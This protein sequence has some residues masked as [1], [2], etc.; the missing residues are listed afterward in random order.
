MNKLLKRLLPYLLVLGVFI[1]LILFIIDRGSRLPVRSAATNAIRSAAP[2]VS[3]SLLHNLQHPLSLLLL[4]VLVIVSAARLFGLLARQLKQPAVVGE[5]VAGICL[6]PSLLGWLWP[7]STSW[8]FPAGSLQSLSFLG[9]IG[10]AFFMFVVGMQMDTANMK[11][12]APHAVMISHVSIV[13][14]FFL[15]VGLAYY[16]YPQFAPAQVG[17]IPFA[18]F[19]GIS[20]SITA[21][22]VL[23]RIVQER[24]LGGTPI[25]S[26]AI[27]CAAAD[28]ITAWCLLAVVVATARSGSLAGSLLTVGLA[29]A[30]VCLMIYGVKPLLEKTVGRMIE[31]GRRQPMVTIVFIVILLS[32]WTAEVIGI[33]ALFGAFFAGVIMPSNVSVKKLIADKI[34]DVSMLLLL[35][36]FFAFTGLRTQVGLIAG[37]Q[38]WW[39]FALI[40]LVAVGGKLCGSAL[41]ARIMGQSWR[42][43][44]SIGAL[45]NTRGLMELVVLNIGYELGI[46]TPPVFA[47]MVLMALATTFMTGPLL[48]LFYRPALPPPPTSALVRSPHD[49]LSVA[50]A[51]GEVA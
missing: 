35:P 46:F 8:L 50:A 3:T 44:L 25:G 18:L 16:L 11:H 33:H 51:G 36:I 22:P 9:Q 38:L 41:T 40:M 19:M 21:F 1:S 47:L 6:G 48:D 5:I 30:F 7:A 31:K 45:M 24:G 26:L 43:S 4:Q 20:M 14:P 10:L 37:G 27:T 15:G 34:E 28:D 17:F 2:A 13:F 42:D 32:A 39:A 12:K 49:A 23:A 29:L